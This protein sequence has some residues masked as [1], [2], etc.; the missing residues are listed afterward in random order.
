MVP[1]NPILTTSEALKEA[2]I[3]ANMEL[4]R[5]LWGSQDGK[6]ALS[7]LSTGAGLALNGEDVELKAAA[8]LLKEAADRLTRSSDGTDKNIG[9]NMIAWIRSWRPPVEEELWP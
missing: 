9:L 2:K 8:E 5:G 4:A 1:E 7:L 6:E 3:D